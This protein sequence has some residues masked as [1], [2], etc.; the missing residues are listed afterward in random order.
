MSPVEESV[1]IRISISEPMYPGLAAQ[2][3]AL[4]RDR[5]FEMGRDDFLEVI[6]GD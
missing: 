1:H 4:R 6:S 2:P 5:L 3:G